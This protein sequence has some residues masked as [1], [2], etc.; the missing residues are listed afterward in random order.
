MPDEADQRGDVSSD[1]KVGVRGKRRERK[2]SEL[3]G[4]SEY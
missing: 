4:R 3:L 2:M 1:R